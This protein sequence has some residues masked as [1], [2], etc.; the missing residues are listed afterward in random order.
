MTSLLAAIEHLQAV[1]LHRDL[2]CLLRRQIVLHDGRERDLVAAAEEARHHQPHHQVL[3]HDGVHHR[4]ADHGV[5]RDAARGR[6]PRGD[7]VGIVEVHR[8]LSVAAGAHVGH[9]V[10]GI[11]KR[12][13]DLGLHQALGLEL[14]QS[15]STDAH[16]GQL[17]R[18][19][20]GLPAE[21]IGQRGLGAHLANRSR[22]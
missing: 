16:V 3:A 15:A 5:L 8:R 14:R 20:A 21:V 18:A 17:H 2:R 9:P 22:P 7:G 12:L 4:A 13:A 1:E 11:G 10:R 6:A 19:L